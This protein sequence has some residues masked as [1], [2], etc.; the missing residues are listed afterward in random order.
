MLCDLPSPTTRE[1]V[2]F[3]DACYLI[4]VMLLTHHLLE[5]F[6]IRQ[7]ILN[8]DQGLVV[9]ASQDTRKAGAAL[10]SVLEFSRVSIQELGTRGDTSDEARS[11]KKKKTVACH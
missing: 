10:F 5:F 7:A 1:L 3:S 6:D 11:I 8:V 2:S 4:L 9:K